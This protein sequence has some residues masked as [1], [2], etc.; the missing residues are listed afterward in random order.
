MLRAVVARSYSLAD[1]SMSTSQPVDGT[2]SPK[3]NI[4]G[5]SRPSQ[6]SPHKQHSPLA[7]SQR[8]LRTDSD[9][10]SNAARE[11]DLA[12]SAN[13][14][15]QELLSIAATARGATPTPIPQRN[16]RPNG[17]SQNSNHEVESDD[18][19]GNWTASNIASDKSNT[20]TESNRAED[21]TRSE[22]DPQLVRETKQ[23]IRALINEVHQL[24]QSHCPIEEFYEGFLTRIVS[25]LAG[26]GGAI[27]RK[28]DEGR[29]ELAYQ[30]N[31]NQS[32]LTGDEAAQLSHHLLLDRIAKNGEA[33]LVAPNSGTVEVGEPGNPTPHLLLID[34]L[35]V[36][37]QTV[38]MVEIFQRAGSGPATQ[39]GY[40]R[41]LTQMTAIA[42]DFVRNHQLRMLT[43]RQSF[44]DKVE[45]FVR[46]IHRGLD[47]KQTAFAIV[48]DGRRIIDCDRVSFAT[49]KR[50]IAKV[51]FVS[52][53]DSIDRR[54]SDI[55]QLSR[56]VT[57]VIKTRQPFWYSGDD[58]SLPPQLEK[59]LHQ[60][61]DQS[62][63]KV[64]GIIP[65]HTMAPKDDSLGAHP[66]GDTAK[67]NLLG[68]LIVEQL[69][70]SKIDTAFRKR[71]DLVST[72]A[73]DA[74]TN[75][76][77]YERIFLRRFWEFVGNRK[78]ELMTGIPT[79]LLGLAAIAVGIFLLC[80]TP[81]K[82]EL[83]A[84]GRL[85]PQTQFE[86]FAPRNGVITE[87]LVPKDPNAIV[88][89]GQVLARLTSDELDLE[90]QSLQGEDRELFEKIRKLTSVLQQSGRNEKYAD[91]LSLEGQEREAVE[92]RKKVLAMLE[93][94]KAER[95][96]LTLV[97]P[98]RGQVVNWQ[99]EEQ[100]LRRPVRMGDNVMTV[101]DPSG[102][103]Q[104]ELEMPEKKMGHL[105][106]VVKDSSQVVRVTFV[107][108]SQANVEYS[109][110]IVRV[111]QKTEI[112][113]DQGNTVLVR[114]DFDKQKLPEELLREG[115]RVTARV[116]CGNASIGYVLFHDVIET[117]HQKILLWF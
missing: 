102:N 52:G 8:A 83:G 44:W 117:V 31:L 32:G 95:E 43:D 46:Q 17:A 28:T 11:L 111:D 104:V 58:S 4:G 48:N 85:T 53:L 73:S 37:Q 68:A 51:Q 23:Q 77:R 63:A 22:V 42:S 6:R 1:P 49:T 25:A 114:V 33:L 13:S 109:G 36:D 98:T 67:S 16:A 88:E 82:F 94:K 62:H 92:K 41:F 14:L 61:L 108:A 60:Y 71:V 3:Q 100:L 35:V 15:T 45:Q 107:L 56:L 116:G 96:K 79:W 20:T 76:L 105:M 78:A 103:W 5:E 66:V 97:S 27:W 72:H 70:E 87:L 89:P 106:R 81:Y 90:I 9:S 65:L 84:E 93:T 57:A 38:G 26:V 75:S 40:L 101:I 55:K 10:L 12:D 64:I 19:S 21:S 39:R 91:K 80:V 110:R 50:R 86:I 54:S 99:V 59:Q 115:T 29:I 30:I 74:L 18:L 47:A 34:T 2:S 69:T 7:T 24:A 113:G 112:R